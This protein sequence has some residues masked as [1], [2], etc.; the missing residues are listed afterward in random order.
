VRPHGHARLR[1]TVALPAG[2]R[3]GR[4]TAF[5]DGRRVAAKRAGATL[6][7]VL[8]ARGGRAVDWAVARR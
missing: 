7:F 2:L 4:V 1:M 3:H 8:K 5:V 6:W